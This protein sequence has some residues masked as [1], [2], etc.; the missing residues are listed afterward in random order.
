[1]TDHANELGAKIKAH[2]D[3]PLHGYQ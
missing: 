2:K 3:K 1:L